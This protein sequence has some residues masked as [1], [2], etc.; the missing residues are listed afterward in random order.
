MALEHARVPKRWRVCDA[1][2]SLATVVPGCDCILGSDEL[3]D[4]RDTVRL[5][6]DAH[7]DVNRASA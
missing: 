2:D 1:Q 6:I 5:L 4:A 7:A 3:F